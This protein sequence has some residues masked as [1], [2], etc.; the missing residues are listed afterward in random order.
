MYELYTYMTV[1]FLKNR[2][3]SRQPSKQSRCNQILIRKVDSF[4]CLRNYKNVL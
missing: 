4:Y 2:N 1:Y 3:K